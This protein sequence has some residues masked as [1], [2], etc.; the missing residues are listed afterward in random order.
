MREFSLQARVEPVDDYPAVS[1]GLEGL[2]NDPEDVKY[3]F[4]SVMRRIA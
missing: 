3:W 4:V 2:R 1:G